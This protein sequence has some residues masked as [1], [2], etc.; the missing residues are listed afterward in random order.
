[1]SRYRSRED[2][3]EDCFSSRPRYLSC[4]DRMCGAW[5]CPRCHP[6]NFRNG[7]YIEESEEGVQDD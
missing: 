2:Y 7:V 5:D 1:M 3:D 4:P 6:E